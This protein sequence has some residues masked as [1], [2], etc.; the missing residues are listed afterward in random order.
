MG[1]GRSRVRA[2]TSERLTGKGAVGLRLF[3]SH[4]SPRRATEKVKGG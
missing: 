3:L 2:G 1:E 4:S